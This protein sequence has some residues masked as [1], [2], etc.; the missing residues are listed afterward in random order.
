MYATTA[1]TDRT[2]RNL[3]IL[4][5]ITHNDKLMT[6]GGFFEI[7]SPTAV[8]SLMR[9]WTGEGRETNVC[10]I[11][12]CV[13]AAQTFINSTI[14]Q[15]QNNPNSSLPMMMH[16]RSQVNACRRMLAALSDALAGL[17]NLRKT[18]HTDAA[19]VCKLVIIEQNIADYL[20][21][22]HDVSRAN[23]PHLASLDSHQVD[24]AE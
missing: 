15:V 10:R 9:R 2:M 18:Y 4:A 3:C 16:Y 7:Y 12:E 14:A 21:L 6:E 13:A 20:A 17:K 23:T 1:C 22:M 19:I 5:S 24:M 8:R 11:E